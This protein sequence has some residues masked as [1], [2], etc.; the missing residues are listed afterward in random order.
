MWIYLGIVFMTG[1]DKCPEIEPTD[2]ADQM[3]HYYPC[4]RKT[5]KWTKKLVFFLLQMTMLNSFIQF[6]NNTKNEKYKKSKYKL[7]DFI[8]GRA[9]KMTESNSV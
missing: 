7:K 5:V 3:L 8:L 2:R 4:S 6:K 1:I 9:E